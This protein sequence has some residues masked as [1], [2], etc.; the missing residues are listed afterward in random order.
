LIASHVA[1][2]G[3]VD[4]VWFVVS[5]QNPLKQSATLLNEYDRLHL[6]NLAIEDDARFKASDAEFKLPK[7]SYT[8]D[9][10]IHL[11][12]K[13]PQHTFSVILGG[14]SYQNLSKWK[15]YQIL[16]NDYQL[17]VYN[18]PNEEVNHSEQS[19]IHILNAPL[20]EISSTEIRK[21]IQQKR[22]IR[23]MLP[24]NVR[25]EIERNGYY[26]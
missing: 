22:S 14:D 4:K 3:L 18:R 13:Y 21:S 12:E 17:I 8:I 25:L 5:P 23:Y 19:N 9:T 16:L 1:D 26:K 20:L 7:P 15:N 10:L 24:E 2:S 11:K 6:V